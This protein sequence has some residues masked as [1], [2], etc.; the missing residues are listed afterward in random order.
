METKKDKN[1]TGG[2]R[3]TFSF[4]PGKNKIIYAKI[5]ED[6]DNW[7]NVHDLFV[8]DIDEED[9]TRLTYNLRANNP[10]V[11]N[12]GNKIVFLFQKDGTTNLGSVDIDGKNFKRLTFFENGEQVYNPK[13]SPDDSYVIFDY[14]YANT[15]DIAKVNSEGGRARG[16]GAERWRGPVVS[17]ASPCSGSSRPAIRR[18]G[19]NVYARNR[20]FS[21]IELLIVMVIAGILAMI[22]VPSYQASVIKS[23]RADGR[24]VNDTAQRLKRCYTQFGA[25]NSDDCAIA[26]AEEITS[27]EGFYVLTVDIPDAATYELTAA[28]TGPQNGAEDCGGLILTNT[29]RRGISVVDGDIE[30]CW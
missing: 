27:Q 8:Y 13:Y 19:M 21:L 24:V 16:A 25:Y 14:S 29:S 15:R 6:N 11:S 7:Y 22:A 20:G 12:D 9:E 30:R 1:I 18:D 26:D 23:R 5:S 3:S 2:V 10:S 4:I 28:P 17:R